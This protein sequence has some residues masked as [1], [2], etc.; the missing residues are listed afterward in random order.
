V[1]VYELNTRNF[2]DLDEENMQENELNTINPNRSEKEVNKEY[3]NFCLV[4][5]EEV[6]DNYC[7]YPIFDPCF[8]KFSE[9]IQ[10]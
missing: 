4:V 3:N 10:K 8:D 9:K 5:E 2:S 6:L 7:C 1:Q